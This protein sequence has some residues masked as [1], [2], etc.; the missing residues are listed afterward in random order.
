MSQSNVTNE[1]DVDITGHFNTSNWTFFL[2]DSQRAFFSN[3]H[4]LI[5][6][7]M[8]DMTQQ[9]GRNLFG[10]QMCPVF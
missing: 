6:I 3:Q 2:S 5:C 9:A 7:N 8:L 4:V 10:V 1:V